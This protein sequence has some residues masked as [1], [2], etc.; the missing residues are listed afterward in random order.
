MSKTNAATKRKSS[1]GDSEHSVKRPNTYDSDSYDEYEISDEED[2]E[3]V[4]DEQK[5]YFTENWAYI[6]EHEYEKVKPFAIAI[7]LPGDIT[8]TYEHVNIATTVQDVLKWLRDNNRKCPLFFLSPIFTDPT[9]V[10]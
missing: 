9:P 10:Y 4:Y 3:D 5:N 7:K 6:R 2:E 8:I 1:D